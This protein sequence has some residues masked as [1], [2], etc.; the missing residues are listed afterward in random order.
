MFAGWAPAERCHLNHEDST[1]S[2]NLEWHANRYLWL[3]MCSTD[4]PTLEVAAKLV[5]GTR[6]AMIHLATCICLLVQCKSTDQ[7]HSPA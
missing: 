6:P 5:R 4:S 3:P 7:S 1:A 2:T